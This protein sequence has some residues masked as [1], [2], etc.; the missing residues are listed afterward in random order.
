M[1]PAAR[2]ARPKPSLNGHGSLRAVSDAE[3][4]EARFEA[5]ARAR[6]EG[7]TPNAIPSW[8]VELEALGEETGIARGR[9]HQILLRVED[10]PPDI[11]AK[12]RALVSIVGNVEPERLSW[13]WAGRL[14]K[15]KL[16]DLAGDPGVGKSTLL[17]D[18]IARLTKGAPLPDGQ[19]PEG[20]TNGLILSAEDGLS[21]TIQPRLAAAGA[22]L[23][24]VRVLHGMTDD[25]GLPRP[26]SL[27][28]DLYELEQEIVVAG[29]ELVVIDPVSAFLSAGIDAHKDHSVR[30][31]LHPL[32]QVAERTGATIVM[33]R[34]LNKSEGG[35]A[36]YRAGGS[37]AFTA[38]ARVQLL[39]AKDP[40]DENRRVLAIVKSN[41]A[42]EAPALSY[43]LLSD[44]ERGCAVVAW[45][46]AT[47][48]T[49][50]QLLAV[51]ADE[52]ERSALKEAVGFLQDYLGTGERQAGEVKKKA[53]DFGIAPRTLQ[54]ATK[55]VG[56]TSRREGFGPGSTYW[57][58]L[59]SGEPASG[60]HGE[61]G[62]HGASRA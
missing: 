35:K 42:A 17:V 23:A 54:R 6:L 33:V 19:L 58:A 24:R 4:A 57:W 34:H 53:R 45:E 43:S 49:A 60:E 36:I 62:E 32:T 25:D 26:W 18:V 56:V 46:G 30:R 39:V 15:G 1:S 61:H 44:E 14:P 2:T 3:E 5:E 27:P 37:I 38:A 52:E 48:H 55:Q 16:V 29:A 13:L 59:E 41:L 20:P 21:D 7:V 11:K 40:G 10:K 47:S 22:D 50:D 51:P 12:R 28:G 31:A 8:Q 9:V